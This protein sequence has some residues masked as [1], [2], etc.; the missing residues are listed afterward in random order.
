MERIKAGTIYRAPTVGGENTRVGKMRLVEEVAHADKNHGVVHAAG[1][2]EV[3]NAAGK[4]VAAGLIAIFAF[5]G[6]AE[7]FDGVTIEV[8]L[9]FAFGDD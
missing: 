8:A 4:L 2:R 5:A 6:Y 1:G 9:V 7:A 3:G